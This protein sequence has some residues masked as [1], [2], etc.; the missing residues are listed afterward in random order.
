[1]NH[2]KYLSENLGKTRGE[3]ERQLTHITIRQVRTAVLIAAVIV[4]VSVMWGAHSVSYSLEMTCPA[5]EEDVSFL[6]ARG[7]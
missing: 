2:L 4:G 3:M 1:M 6:H 5:P 7:T